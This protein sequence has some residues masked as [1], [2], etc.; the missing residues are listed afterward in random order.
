MVPNLK[1][2]RFNRGDRHGGHDLQPNASGYKVLKVC[3]G[4]CDY[5]KKEGLPLGSICQ[6][7][8]VMPEMTFDNDT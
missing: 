8:E 7:G 2:P 4:P 3:G 5:L 6:C 1:E